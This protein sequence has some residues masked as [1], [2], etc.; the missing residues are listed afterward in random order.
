M[1]FPVENRGLNS[2]RQS[3]YIENANKPK[4]IIDMPRER[5]LAHT[6]LLSSK[7]ITAANF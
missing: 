4:L 7:F 2:E 1:R 3:V 6:E 5:Q